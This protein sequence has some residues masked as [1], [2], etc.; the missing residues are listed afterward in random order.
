[1][2]AEAADRPNDPPNARSTDGSAKAARFA[3]VN[4]P[5]PSK[6]P[7]PIAITA[8]TARNSRT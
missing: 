2:T 8:G 6:K 7:L 3:N 5:E 4:A 1:M